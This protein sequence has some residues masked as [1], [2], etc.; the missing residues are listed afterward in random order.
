M[1][2]TGARRVTLVA[3]TVFALAILAPS[4]T[5]A[6]TAHLPN[7]GVFGYGLSEAP[8][9]FSSGC[10][11]GSLNLS[12]LAWSGWGAPQATAT[13]TVSLRHCENTCSDATYESFPATLTATN[14][15]RC[16][17]SVG[18]T[19]VYLHLVYTVQFTPGNVLGEPAGPKNYSFDDPECRTP[20]YLVGIQGKARIG[21]FEEDWSSDAWQFE[22]YF[23][24]PSSSKPG[25]YSTCTKKWPALG[26][27]VD[28]WAFGDVT[29]ACGDGLFGRALLTSKIW[30][31]GKGVGPGSSARKA[32]RRSIGRCGA[33]YSCQGT[34]GYVMS[35]HRSECAG[36]SYPTVI[37]RTKGRRVSS[38]IVNTTFCE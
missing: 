6:A 37:A 14:L 16:A 27:T 22:T 34:T 24:P 29:D 9:E 26:M 12:G 8:V 38:L 5:S 18:P 19:N 20:L 10:T 4:S 25:R 23:Q 30:R 15:Q 11:G 13:G 33:K 1:K 35:V 36:G 31:T 7:C 32:R 3:G 2:V 21:A 17:S 28:F